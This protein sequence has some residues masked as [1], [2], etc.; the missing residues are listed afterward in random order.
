MTLVIVTHDWGVVAD[1]CDDTIVMYAG[2][3]V[4]RASVEE[5]FASPRHPYTEA[6]LAANP[7]LATD[8]PF[9]TIPGGVPAPERWPAGC[10]FRERCHYSQADC[11]S[12]HVPAITVDANHV[13]RCLHHER[14]GSLLLQ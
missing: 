3:I 8:G 13:S 10:R 6:L 5:L 11:A 14:V 1:S 7:H 9:E 12:G 2:Q 4:E